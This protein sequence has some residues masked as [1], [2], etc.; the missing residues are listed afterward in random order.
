MKSEDHHVHLGLSEVENILYT[1]L[2]NGLWKTYE[3]NM[4]SKLD[5]NKLDI[6][7]ITENTINSSKE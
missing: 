5:I 7:Q 2:C 3:T 4:H 6:K 1:L